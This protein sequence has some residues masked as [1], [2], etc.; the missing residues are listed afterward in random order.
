MIMKT[1]LIAT[2]NA[3]KVREINAKLRQQGLTDIKLLDLSAYPAYTPPEENGAA[4]A[5]NA[6]LKA[7][8]AASYSGQLALA[9]DSG[10]TVAAL[11]GAP[12]IYSARYAGAGH[13]DAANNA[14]LLAKLADVPPK[15]RQAAFCCVIALAQPGGQ[16][17]LAEAKVE[18]LILQAPRGSSGFGYDP[19][20][21]LPQYG[22][23]MA[24]LAPEEKNRISHRALALEKAMP[25][26]ENLPQQL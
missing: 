24:E 9:D 26:I 5:E 14:K 23:S 18:G 25:L 8:A 11:G 21:Y 19:L 17:W 15:R 2:A 7:R 22:C 6:M 13:N 20:F 12:G 4:F 3:H 10:L 1:L 16:C